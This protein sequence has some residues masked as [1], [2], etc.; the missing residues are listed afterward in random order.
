MALLIFVAQAHA[1]EGVLT[2]VS[3]LSVRASVDGSSNSRVIEQKI[4]DSVYAALRAA[5]IPTSD[6][7]AADNESS[8]YL[9]YELTIRRMA[10]GGMLYMM[11]FT[12]KVKASNPYNKTSINGILASSSHVNIAKTTAEMTED[13]NQVVGQTTEKFLLAWRAQN[14]LPNAFKL[15]DLP[16][17]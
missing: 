9:H 4:V 14:P 5:R 17:D 1:T 7:K 3:P 10:D 8:P 11:S 15:P 12:L 2:E 6:P 16:T 13:L